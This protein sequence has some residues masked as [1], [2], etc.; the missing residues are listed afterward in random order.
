MKAI[1][2]NTRK[3]TVSEI[4]VENAYPDINKAIGCSTITVGTEWEEGGKR[5]TLFVDD[6]GLLVSGNPCFRIEGGHQ[7]FAGCGVILGTN[8]EG[9]SVDASLTVDEVR[10]MVVWTNLVVQ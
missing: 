1:L 3:R 6:E 2:I 5:D 7:P 9:E 8:D 10:D 4:Q